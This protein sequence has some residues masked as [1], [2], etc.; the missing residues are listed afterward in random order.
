MFDAGQLTGV[1]DWE[2]SCLARAEADLALQ[3]VG[4][5]L[6]AAPADSGLLRPPSDAEWIAR[7]RK[8]GGRPLQDFDYFKRLT[9]FMVVIAI[10]SLRRNMPAEAA[11]AQEYFLRPLWTLLES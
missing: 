4:N 1:V 5:E 9:A 10:H 2:M 3:C 8:A 6:F 11:A 7:Y